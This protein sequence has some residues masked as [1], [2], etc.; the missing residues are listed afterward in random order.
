MRQPSLLSKL[1]GFGRRTPCFCANPRHRPVSPHGAASAARQR[2]SRLPPYP[3]DPTCRRSQSSA[4]VLANG[5]DFGSNYL[6]VARTLCSHCPP[7]CLPTER[8]ARQQR[9][10][11]TLAANGQNQR[12]LWKISSRAAWSAVTLRPLSQ[13]PPTGWGFDTPQSRTVL[14]TVKRPEARFRPRRGLDRQK[15]WLS[16]TA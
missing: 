13:K 1:E 5:A 12:K 3:N 16:R 6:P 4:L 2:L 7:L 8:R 9:L 10:L 15:R 14:R 11:L